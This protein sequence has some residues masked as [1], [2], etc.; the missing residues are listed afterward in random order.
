MLVWGLKWVGVWAG[1][2]ITALEHSKVHIK[3]KFLPSLWIF[4]PFCLVVQWF[5]LMLERLQHATSQKHFQDVLS[6]FNR[7]MRAK[8]STTIKRA[9][10]TSYIILAAGEGEKMIWDSL[11]ID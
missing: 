5:Y 8:K 1:R 2:I 6:L 3:T 4:S 7:I 9:I 11:N 10:D